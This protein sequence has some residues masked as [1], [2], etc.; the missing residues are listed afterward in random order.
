[1]DING[2]TTSEFVN[3][4]DM[5][6]ATAPSSFF[7]SFAPNSG[8][9]TTLHGVT[10]SFNNTNSA[11]VING[12]PSAADTTAAQAVT[13]GLEVQ[14][15]LSQ[16]GSPQGSVKVFADINGGGNNFLSNQFLTGLP[17]A[18]GSVG[19]T[20]NGVPNTP[21][22]PGGGKFDFSGT[23]NMFFTVP[24][25][26]GNNTNATW[27]STTGGTWG[28]SG[29]WTPG[30]PSAAGDSA[31]FG[32]SVSGNATITLDGNRTLGQI[33]FNNATRSYTIAPGT[34]SSSVLTIDDTGDAGG[35]NPFINVQAG[36]HFITAN[37]ALA[38][39]VTV[40]TLDGTGLLVS[41]NISGTGPLTK[42]GNGTLELAGSNSFSGGITSFAGVVQLDNSDAAGAGSISMGDPDVDN[43]P[44]TLIL[45]TSGMNLTNPITTNRDLA[46]NNNLRT[47]AGTYASGN[48]TVSSPITVD[49][50]VVFSAAS[51]A[52]LTVSGV[53][54]DGADTHGSARHAIRVAGAG[55]VTLTNAETNTG[56]T[57]VD[58]GTL[59]LASSASLN[60]GSINVFTPGTMYIN[61]SV[62]ATEKIYT[63]GKTILA[64]NT[65]TTDAKNL[66]LG[67]ITVDSGGLFQIAHSTVT[68]K[69][70]VLTSGPIEFFTDT[71]GRVDVTNNVLI[72]PHDQ[73]AV[74]GLLLAGQIMTS[75]PGGTVGYGDAGG[76]LTRVQF[77]LAGDGDLSGN[78]DLTD[79]TYLAANFNNTSGT[80]TWLQGDYNYDGNVDL[81]DFTYLASNFNKTAPVSAGGIG[82][83]VPEPLLTPAVLIGAAMLR[84]RRK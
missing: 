41:G 74:R 44:A 71:T 49:G 56:D 17:T 73:N 81:T 32:T 23:P 13:T 57:F 61:G 7:G 28:T 35:V 34:P 27:A 75:T 16:L 31:V 30:S 51:G 67:T 20:T 80:A 21:Y 39:G 62:P 42:A 11:G 40:T 43:L 65:S 59:V 54:Q 1:L 68:A 50:G 5:T 24:I 25:P 52:S 63:Q 48:S 83:P 53:I 10:F 66:S 26:A 19:G 4:Y 45:G 14:I 55:T 79:F 6:Q 77:T 15:P 33:T 37:V 38:N 70:V 58:S 18:V 22:G 69:P 46:A 3:Q 78:V 82:A 76:G 72:A 12:A 2:N 47:I 36:I 8:T 60:G 29:N 84:R 64:G 9:G